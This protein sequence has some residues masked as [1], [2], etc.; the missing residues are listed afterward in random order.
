M[1]WILQLLDQELHVDSQPFYDFNRD[2]TPFHWRH[3]HEKL[4]QSVKERISEDTILAV[5][6]TDYS[7]L[8]HV[9]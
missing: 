1:P 4:F 6:S 8:I 7:F 9:D 2:L 5:P 3:G